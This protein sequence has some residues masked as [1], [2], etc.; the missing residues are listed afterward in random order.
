MADNVSRMGRQIMYTYFLRNP[1]EK[2]KWK[3]EQKLEENF[4]ANFRKKNRL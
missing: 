1:L 3:V 2:A 4:K